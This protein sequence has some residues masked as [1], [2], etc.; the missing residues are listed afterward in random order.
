MRILQLTDLHL[1]AQNN[2]Q[3]DYNFTAVINFIKK[4]KTELNID[5]IIVTGDISHEGQVNSYRFFFDEIESVDLPY[6]IIPGN[7]DNH[8]TLL[9]CS[10]G[11]NKLRDIDSFS[12][13][14]WCLYSPD[15]VVRGEDY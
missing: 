13:S 14:T 11:R 5:G 1:S 4:R 15:T 2:S 10:S 9:A 8:E 7:H 6:S 12:N 3:Y